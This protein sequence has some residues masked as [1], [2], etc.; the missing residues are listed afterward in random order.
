MDSQLY[1][2]DCEIYDQRGTVH[3]Q[4]SMVY[5]IDAYLN[6]T[7][8]MVVEAIEIPIPPNLQHRHEDRY[9]LP[10][11][12]WANVI[13]LWDGDSELPGNR[14]YDKH[15]LLFRACSDIWAYVMWM[16]KG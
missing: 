7:E 1:T 14:G 2:L 4:G 6:Q 16:V 15:G 13:S 8:G 10:F 3:P 11:N 12:T 5:L 9:T